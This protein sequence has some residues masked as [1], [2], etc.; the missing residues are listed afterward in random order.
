MTEPAG[1]IEYAVIVAY[2]AV[3][4]GLGLAVR[5]FSSGIS[6]YFRSGCRGTWWL[7]GSSAFMQMFSAWTFTGAA[8]AAFEAG[9]SVMVIF[10]ANVFALFLTFLFLGPWFRQ[11]RAI[12]APE[13]IRLRFGT[14]TQQS[15]AWLQGFMGLLYAAIWLWGLSTFV[16]AVFDFTPVSDALGVSE[17][18]LVIVATGLIVLVYSVSGGSWAVMATDFVQSLILIPL[19]VLVAYLCLKHIGGVGEMFNQIEEQGL[20]ERFEFIKD[21]DA[22]PLGKYG[23]AFAVATVIYKTIAY[24]TLITAQKYFGVKDGREARKAALLACGLMAAGMF[25]WFIPP[26]V[27]RLTMNDAVMAT[28]LSKPAEASYAIIA[29]A[30]LPQGL[31]GLIVVAML[32][33]TMSS[34]DSG[35]NRN[36]AVYVKDIDPAIRGLLRIEPAT[37]RA[38]FLMGQVVSLVLGVLIVGLALY[39]S[40]ADGKGVFEGMLNIGA[41]VALP[42]SIPM[43]LALFIRKAPR[44]SAMASIGVTLVPAA[45]GFFAGAGWMAGLAAGTPFEELLSSEWSYQRKVFVNISI[46]IAVFL[47]SVPFWKTASEGY[48][49]QVAEFFR[50]MHTPVDF[51]KEVGEA[52][53]G[54]QLSIIGLFSTV[55][56]CFVL[57]LAALPGND[58]SGR[59]AILFVGGTV[60]GVGGLLMYTG[61]R[62]RLNAETLDKPA[63]RDDADGGR[64][65]GDEPSQGE[66]ETR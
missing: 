46:G 26:V 11:L 56:G 13:I 60:S 41:V 42:M 6:D 54:G 65:P 66:G 50:R 58:L 45:V 17:V 24:S 33:A 7:V 4:V 44:W 16:A 3:L 51:E 40:G 48:R 37:E 27:A 47:A 1:W 35:L 2:L 53:D 39:F 59:L 29:V 22:F 62:Y 23:L 9:W 55:I 38:R 30:L 31:T 10:G 34:M 21:P 19:T 52:N 49:L 25:I 8:G 32:A 15:Y 43:M 28:E 5:R 14:V 64:A 61:R 12:T 18:Q 57:L 20:T 36:A 63:D